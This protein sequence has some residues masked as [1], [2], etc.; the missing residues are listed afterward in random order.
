MRVLP[1]LPVSAALGATGLAG[2]GRAAPGPGVSSW[3]SDG[4]PRR[5]A[6]GPQWELRVLR[7]GGTKLRWTADAAQAHGLAGEAAYS[8]AR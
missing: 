1:R 4:Q 6:P 3:D 8:P 7:L 5:A 2:A